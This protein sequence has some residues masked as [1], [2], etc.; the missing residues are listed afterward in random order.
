MGRWVEGTQGDLSGW[1]T[2]LPVSDGH[3]DRVEDSEGA[4]NAGRR[5]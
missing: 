1:R 4:E 5:V 2:G 3:N